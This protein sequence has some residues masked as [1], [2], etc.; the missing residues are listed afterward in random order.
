MSFKACRPL[1]RWGAWGLTD[2]PLNKWVRHS[3]QI[4]LCISKYYKESLQGWQFVYSTY[5]S[6]MHR[7]V[8]TH[9]MHSESLQLTLQKVLVWRAPSLIVVPITYCRDPDCD[10]S[11]KYHIRNKRIGRMVR[12]TELFCGVIL[13]CVKYHIRLSATS[14]CACK[15]ICVS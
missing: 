6:F 5:S 8:H 2:Q 9:R 11:E 7:Q 14:M 1:M 4:H 10:I 3:Q 12:D 13:R 15:C